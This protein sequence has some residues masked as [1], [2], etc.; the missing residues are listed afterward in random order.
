MLCAREGDAKRSAA[1]TRV[2]IDARMRMDIPL[3]R[4]WLGLDIGCLLFPERLYGSASDRALFATQSDDGI[5]AHGA[6][7]RDVARY[8]R[9]N[10]EQPGHASEIQGI[11]RSHAIEQAAEKAG[12]RE[13]S[14]QP[15]THTGES[16]R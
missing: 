14:G 4:C 9:H 12:E 6:A 7:R 2:Q 8:H 1:K 13:G 3:L 15:N 5:E 16:K 11:R 10:G